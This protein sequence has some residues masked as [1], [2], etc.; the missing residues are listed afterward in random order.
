MAKIRLTP[1]S[2]T[3]P[4]GIR[5]VGSTHD[6]LACLFMWMQVHSIVCAHCREYLQKSG[7]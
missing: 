7:Q 1:A 5:K 2:V 4:C 3:T 6:S